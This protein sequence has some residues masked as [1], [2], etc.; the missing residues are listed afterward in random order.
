MNLYFLKGC[1]LNRIDNE[2]YANYLNDKCDWS[3]QALILSTSQEKAWQGI[4]EYEQ[5]RVKPSKYEFNGEN[6][7][8]LKWIGD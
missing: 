5:G 6:I 1:Y 7:Y 8:C 2:G 4:K 3:N